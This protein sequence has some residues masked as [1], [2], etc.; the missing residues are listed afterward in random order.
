[1]SILLEN[2]WIWI[3]VSLFVGVIG[4]ILFLQSRNIKVGISFFLCVVLILATGF[5]LYYLTETDLK[6]VSRSISQLAVSLEADDTKGVLEF[7]APNAERTRSI[8]QKNMQNFHLTQVKIRNLDI[9]INSLTS[10]PS[11]QVNLKAVI[12]WKTKGAT[13]EGLVFDKPIYQ[14]VSFQFEMEKG[15]QNRWM[16][17]D[18]LDWSI[19]N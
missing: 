3:A 14:P 13:S 15:T 8:A 6:S 9:M 10:P 5:S 11:A 12:Y 19:T 16:I 7:I 1:M 2:I 17:T 18:Q 4:L